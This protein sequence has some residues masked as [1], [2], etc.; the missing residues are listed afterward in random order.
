MNLST[1]RERENKIN[2][3]AVI[4]ADDISRVKT[5]L[6][7][8]IRYAHLNF[9]GKA[10]KLEPAFA[11]NILINIMKSPLKTCCEAASVVPLAEDASVAIGRIRKIHPPAHIIIVSPKYNIFHDLIDSIDALPE[12]ELDL[13]KIE[14]EDT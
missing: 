13:G 14:L 6:C 11:D 3:L 4:R 1:N 9:I 2:S 12:I 10:K 8:L 5:A 7:D